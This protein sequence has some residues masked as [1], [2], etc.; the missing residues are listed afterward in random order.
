MRVFFNTVSLNA[1]ATHFKFYQCFCRKARLSRRELG[2]DGDV[3]LLHEFVAE[4]LVPRDR[5]PAGCRG[6]T[7]GAHALPQ[8][9]YHGGQE[10]VTL[11]LDIVCD[12]DI[13][14]CV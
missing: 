6:R 4:L 10:C 12:L 1:K 2:K 7:T 8:M 13:G 9:V 5:L 11:T 14:Y 3:S